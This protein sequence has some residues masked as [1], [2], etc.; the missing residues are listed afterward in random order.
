MLRTH[1]SNLIVFQSGLRALGTLVY[2]EEN[3]PII[4][5]EGATRVIVDGMRLHWEDS[6]TIQLGINVIENL[7]AENVRCV[8]IV[9]IDFDRIP[10]SLSSLK[11]YLSNKLKTVYTNC[12]K[13]IFFFS[14]IQIEHQ[15]TNKIFFFLHFFI[16][17]LHF[18]LFFCIFYFYIQVPVSEAPD[19][20]GKEHHPKR[21]GED[22]LQVIHNEGATHI[23]LAAIKS[24]EYNPSLIMS[25]ID[26][27][28]NITEDETLMETI[29]RDGGIPIV[30]EAL[31][32]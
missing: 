22:T 17:F 21:H 15:T 28:L 16:F 14:I 27:L 23:V 11:A 18:V 30:M 7:S 20:V 8:V 9:Q 6:D 29:V 25:S 5:G 26:A 31:R 4:V 19:S 32:R 3:C 1:F 12:L 10:F 2:C 24:F 13:L